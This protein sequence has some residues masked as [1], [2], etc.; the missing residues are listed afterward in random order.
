M[1]DFRLIPLCFWLIFPF[2]LV[3]QPPTPCCLD[4]TCLTAEEAEECT[5]APGWNPSDAIAGGAFNCGIDLPPGSLCTSWCENN[6]FGYCVA[7]LDTEACNYGASADEADGCEYADIGY[8][9]DGNCL[10]DD[11]DGVC[12]LDEVPGCTSETACNYD[13]AAT[14]DDGSCEEFTGWS[15]T[16]DGMEEVGQFGTHLYFLTDEQLTWPNAEALAVEA[17][18]H[19]VA[20]NSQ[21]EQ[22][23]LNDNFNPAAGGNELFIGLYQDVNDPN[24][25]ENDGGWKWSSGEDLTYTNWE[26]TEPSGGTAENYARFLSN[27]LW[28]DIYD[29]YSHRG[30]VEIEGCFLAASE[31][32]CTDEAAC[33]YDPAAGVDDGSC[34]YAEYG[35]DCDGNCL[36]ED[37]DGICLL[38]EIAGCTDS[39]AVNYYPIF[40][41]DDGGCVYAEDLCSCPGDFNGDGFISVIDLLIFLGYINYYCSDL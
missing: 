22:T 26:S 3:A 39:L 30:I 41:E 6:P 27:Y 21:A 13:S 10:D 9:C 16:I 36:D 15:G 11:G 29:T 2:T 5:A 32:G 20:V 37:G 18:G 24:Y 12:N 31:P 38:D 7:C 35:F 8:D 40:T 34:T 23:F 25:F 1:T 33:N 28:G 14:E 4:A 17:G 19:L